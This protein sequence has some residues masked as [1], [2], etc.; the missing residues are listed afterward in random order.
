[1]RINQIRTYKHKVEVLVYGKEGQEVVGSFTVTFK[2]LPTDADL[3]NNNAAYLNK[4]LEKVEGIE[5]YDCNGQL[6]TDEQLKQA[7]IHNSQVSLA[8]ISA[9]NESIAKKHLRL[10]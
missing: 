2:I 3:P 1:M 7:M 4:I 5:M 8:I 9:Y 10:I 6:L